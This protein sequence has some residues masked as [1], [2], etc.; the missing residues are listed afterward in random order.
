MT[1]Q[2]GQLLQMLTSEDELRRK[3][4]EALDLIMQHSR[5]LS[6]DAEIKP[7]AARHSCATGLQK[8]G[9]AS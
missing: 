9:G 8:K 6:A 3:V 4:E 1:L 5:D 2:P 7:E